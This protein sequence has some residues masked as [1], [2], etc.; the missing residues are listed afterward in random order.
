LLRS[1]ANLLFS[2][3]NL[4]CSGANLLFSGASRL[5][6]GANRLFAGGRCNFVSLG[7]AARNGSDEGGSVGVEG[8]VNAVIPPSSFASIFAFCATPLSQKV[9]T[10][11]VNFH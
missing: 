3:A 5:F 10:D 6:S 7:F 8:S 11:G 9:W 4:L 1:G 2:G